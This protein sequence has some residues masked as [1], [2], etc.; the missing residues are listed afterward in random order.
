MPTGQLSVL[1]VKLTYCAVWTYGPRAVRLTANL[2]NKRE[3]EYF[4]RNLELVPSD[5]GRFEFEING[6]ML[7][8]KKQVGRHAEEGEIEA[9]VETYIK[10]YAA[11]HD[12]YIPDFE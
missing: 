6:D 9:M 3:V 4:I 10:Q 8:S 7:F 12:I 11:E 5:G 2:L 1:D